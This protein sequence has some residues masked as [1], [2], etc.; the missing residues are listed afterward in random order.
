VDPDTEL[1]LE[2]STTDAEHLKPKRTF[3]FNSKRFIT[4]L[5]KKQQVTSE[6]PTFVNIAKLLEDHKNKLSSDVVHD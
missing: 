2:P 5:L 4:H 3:L 1:I 6:R